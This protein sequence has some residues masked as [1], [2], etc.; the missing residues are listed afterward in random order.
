MGL[1]PSIQECLFSKYLE[2]LAP[3]PAAPSGRRRV[4]RRRRRRESSQRRTETIERHLEQ[5]LEGIARRSIRSPL[6]R[7]LTPPPLPQ[8]RPSPP[9]GE[10][11]GRC[12]PQNP[13]RGRRAPKTCP[14]FGTGPR[15]S[16]LLPCSCCLNCGRECLS[17]CVFGVRNCNCY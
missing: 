17:A 7:E 10:L 13:E 8:R 11:R 12:A 1:S 14:R 3:P 2:P 6:S 16:S 4:Q 9:L 5:P 15:P